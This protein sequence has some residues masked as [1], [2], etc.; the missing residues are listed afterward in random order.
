M[1]TL[2]QEI[3]K[4]VH[5]QPVP[6]R[7]LRPQPPSQLEMPKRSTRLAVTVSFDAMRAQAQYGKMEMQRA[8]AAPYAQSASQRATIPAAAAAFAAVAL[9]LGIFYARSTDPLH[10]EFDGH[11]ALL[12]PRRSSFT[13]AGERAERVARRFAAWQADQFQLVKDAAQLGTI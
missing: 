1:H 10:T 2:V 12:P 3:S 5:I 7:P 8:R 9:A 4:G 6:A 11:T 13:V